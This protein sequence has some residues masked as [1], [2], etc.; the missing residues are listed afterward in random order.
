MDQFDVLVLGTGAAG[1]TAAITA[2]EHGATVGL[3]E[4]AASVGGH[5]I[6]VSTYDYLNLPCWMVFDH[7]Y[8]TTDGLA[9]YKGDGAVPEW[10]VRAPTVDALAET[11]GIPPEALGDTVRRFAAIAADSDDPDFGR[12]RSAHDTWWGDASLTGLVTATLGPVDTPPYYAVEVRSGA[13]DPV[14]PATGFWSVCGR[15]PQRRGS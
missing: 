3:F 5:T 4:K 7:H 11:L 13:P 10:M 15:R 12:G 2:H 9:G 8:L 1:L 6:D 14:S